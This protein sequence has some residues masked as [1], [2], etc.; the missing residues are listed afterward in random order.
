M[1]VDRRRCERVRECVVLHVDSRDKRGRVGVTRDRSETGVLFVTPSH[2]QV[3][4][5]LTLSRPD[6]SY[7]GFEADLGVV[8]RVSRTNESPMRWAVAVAFD[9]V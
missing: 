4:D 1:I 5:R 8:V 9:D 2:F 7:P 6:R 3:G